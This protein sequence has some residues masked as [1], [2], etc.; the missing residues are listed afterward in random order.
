MTGNGD[1][2]PLKGDGDVLELDRGH[3][4]TTRWVYLVPRIHTGKQLKGSMRY[5]EHSTTRKRPREGEAGTPPPRVAGAL[6]PATDGAERWVRGF[7]TAERDTGHGSPIG[8]WP[9]GINAPRGPE[10]PHAGRGQQQHV[11]TSASRTGALRSPHL[12]SWSPSLPQLECPWALVPPSMS[13]W[14]A[15]RA[16]QAGATATGPRLLLTP[17]GLTV[18]VL[19]PLPG[20]PNRTQRVLGTRTA[21]SQLNLS[22]E[23]SAAMRNFLLEK[24]P[25]EAL[26]SWQSRPRRTRAS[27]S[28]LSRRRRPLAAPHARLT[29]NTGTLTHAA[30]CTRTTHGR[31]YTRHRAHGCTP[32]SSFPPPGRRRAGATE[33]TGS[34]TTGLLPDA[35]PPLIGRTCSA[36]EAE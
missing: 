26:P 27:V 11:D 18:D 7:G 8:P 16:L 34:R 13:P 15:Q 9:S 3:G 1:R 23:Q 21:N 29:H 35:P 20:S 30:V 28:P 5:H 12:V 25:A 14:W 10:R 17:A 6:F 33:P 2:A 24:M 4:C 36:G 22:K 31:T 32:V 19:C